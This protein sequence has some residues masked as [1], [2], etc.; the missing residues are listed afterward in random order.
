MK[1]QP[2]NEIIIKITKV[3]NFYVASNMTP[4]T[5]CMLVDKFPDDPRHAVDRLLDQILSEY[6]LQ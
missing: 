1:K 5:D 2:L 4:L 3:N 6:E